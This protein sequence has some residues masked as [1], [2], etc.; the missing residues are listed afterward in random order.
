MCVF[1][2]ALESNQNQKQ[3]SINRVCVYVCIFMVVLY[4]AFYPPNIKRVFIGLDLKK[5]ENTASNLHSTSIVSFPQYLQNI[6]VSCVLKPVR[7]EIRIC[8]VLLIIIFSFW[9]L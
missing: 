9:L 7:G 4:S 8:S 2:R 5:G 1:L 6:S 3:V